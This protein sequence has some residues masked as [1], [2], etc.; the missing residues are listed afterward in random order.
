MPYCSANSFVNGCTVKPKLFALSSV[1]ALRLLTRGVVSSGQASGLTFTL[2]F[3]PNR[4]TSSTT[5]EPI[6]FPRISFFSCCAV[7]TGLPSTAVTTSPAFSS[8]FAAGPSGGISKTTTPSSTPGMA[9]RYSVSSLRERIR[10][11]R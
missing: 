10:T 5:V 2:M 6:F 8:D 7:A 1:V 9:S 4:C 3:F 11:P